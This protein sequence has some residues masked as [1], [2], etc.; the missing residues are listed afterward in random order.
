[1]TDHMQPTNPSRIS[2]LL[3]LVLLFMALSGAIFL[4]DSQLMQW[5]VDIRVL[6]GSNAL[7]FGVT[8]LASLWINRSLRGTGGQALLKALYGGFMIRFFLLASVAFVYI[9]AQRKQVNLPGLIGAAFF[10]VLYLWI[11]VR[12][13]RPVLKSDSRHA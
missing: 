2:M 3:P 13:L 6:H 4:L 9:I 10:Y 1:M 5:G 7:L 11:E 12:S 8:A